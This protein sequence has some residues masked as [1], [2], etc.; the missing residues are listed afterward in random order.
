MRHVVIATSLLLSAWSGCGSS[1]NNQSDEVAVPQVQEQTPENLTDDPQNSVVPLGSRGTGAMPGPAPL[2]TIPARFQ[3]R[4]GM[5]AADCD[6]STGADK[7]KLTIAGNR[8]SFF[9]SRGQATKITQTQPTQIAFDLPMS[10]EGTNWNERTTLT[11]LDDVKMLVRQ[12]TA[13]GRKPET[14]RY[15]RCPA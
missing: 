7:G 2:A 15:V 14:T 1:G 8:L 6:P 3:G 11:M 4:W 13:P 5:T 9:E 12:T 10:G